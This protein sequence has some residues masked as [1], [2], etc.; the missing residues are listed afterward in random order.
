M[1]NTIATSFPFARQI[2]PVGKS[3]HY[4]GAGI[5]FCVHALIVSSIYF[6]G[7][8]LA[9]FK[10][11]LVIDFSIEQISKPAKAKKVMA[12][13]E[14]E[15]LPP[16]PVPVREEVVLPETE[17]PDKVETVE[18]P[19]I[20]PLEK[21]Q[22]VVEQAVPKP[23]IPEEIE[24]EVAEP[25]EIV[26]EPVLADMDVVDDEQVEPPSAQVTT[27]INQQQTE[28]LLSLHKQ[29]YIK[30]HFANIMSKV[31]K[32]IVYPPIAR[33][34]GWQ[35]KVIVSFVI[36]L[37]GSVK[38]ITIRESSGHAILDKNA[39]DVI[40]KGSPFPRPPVSA[41]LIIPVVYTLS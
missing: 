7:P 17:M 25:E 15:L 41:E 32:R 6:L 24:T 3:R 37:D 13:P 20:V 21:K 8:S 29:K 23:V 38:D 22:E 26:Q 9:D 10:P 28:N 19:K 30:D 34:M 36:C 35:G 12:Q 33:K 4:F 18:V 14:P 31:R 11:P 5:S 2:F 16:P 27:Q 39:I 40:R 1:E